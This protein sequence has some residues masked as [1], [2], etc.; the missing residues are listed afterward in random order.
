[1][2]SRPGAMLAVLCWIALGTT[3]RGA[4]T[5][6]HTVLLVTID[7]LRWQEV[8]HG[9]EKGL[10]DR[11]TG[12]VREPA[13]IR[14][15]FWSESDRQRRRQLMP[16]L[17]D[18]MA[19]E[20]QI[21]G[22]PDRD[23]HV[24]CSNERYFSYPGYHELLCGF[25]DAKI[26]SNQ[27]RNNPNPTVLEW[28]HHRPGF[29][30]RVAAFTSWDVFPFILNRDRSGIYV[31]AGWQPL[32]FFRNP[33]EQSH[34]NQLAAEIPRY[35]SGVRYD[36]FTFKGAAEYWH[37]KQPRLLYVALGEPDD[38]AHAGRYDL[39]LQATQRCDRYLRQLWESVQPAKG[40]AA[41][42][43]LI[44][45]TDHGR[46][47]GREGWKSHGATFPGSDRIWIAILGPD[48]RAAGV[49]QQG[50]ATQ[51]QVA[52][53]VAALLGEDFAATNPRIA[54]VLPGVLTP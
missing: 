38:W 34:W 29:A 39:Y 49:R 54:P 13:H 28:L 26:D 3:A 47:D 37:R 35:W 9:A 42:T 31:N 44:V 46:G 43:T 14:E 52:A 16:F 51:A 7:G 45:T 48:T 5:Q 41:H 21:L 50:S 30:G 53:T 2:R 19:V 32:E 10:I 22:D 4:Q 23:F 1:M 15:Q 24:L 40:E 27:K 11:D 33:S 18:V 17:W 8:F 20:G 6:T 36:A 12:G 25:A